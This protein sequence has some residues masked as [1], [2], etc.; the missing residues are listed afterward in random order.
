MRLREV[1]L[2]GARSVAAVA[3]EFPSLSLYAVDAPPEGV[4][5]VEPRTLFGGGPRGWSLDRR[6]DDAAA[7]AV[8][9]ER[10]ADAIGVLTRLQRLIDRRNHASSTADFDTAL[11]RHRALHDLARPLVR[12]DY[13]HARDAWHWLLRLDGAASLAA[14]LAALFHDVER[15][16]SEA[17]VRV[18]QHAPNYQAFKEAHAR[19]GALLLRAT[20]GDL[21]SEEVVARAAALVAAHERPRA[22]DGDDDDG[23]D[24]YSRERTLVTDAD[25]LSFFSLNSAGYLDYF[26]AAQAARKVAWTLR[27]LSWRG[28]ERLGAIELRAD[29]R[30]LCVQSM[31]ALEDRA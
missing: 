24:G 9:A 14:Q 18:E 19:G 5:C 29:V 30:A 6:L 28:R 25:A 16:R 27:R 2:V 20:I 8:P 31:F 11:A 4:V 3:A 1:H 15:L 13:D 10:A 7:L 21:V 12:A 17:D 23:T 22:S 26:G